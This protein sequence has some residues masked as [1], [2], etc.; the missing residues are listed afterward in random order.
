[1]RSKSIQWDNLII[2]PF[3]LSA[4][5]NANLATKQIA[6]SILSAVVKRCSGPGPTICPSE[7]SLA[8][9]TCQVSSS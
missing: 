9:K 8:L 1:M 5:L 6:C 4:G 3:E 7:P 2:R